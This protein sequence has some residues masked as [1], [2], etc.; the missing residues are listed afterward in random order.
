[1]FN[2]VNQENS[3]RNGSQ[4]SEDTQKQF[5]PVAGKLHAISHAIVFD[6]IEIKKVRNHLYFLAYCHGQLDIKFQSLIGK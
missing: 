5:T 4:N 1:M 6:E 3:Q 2:D